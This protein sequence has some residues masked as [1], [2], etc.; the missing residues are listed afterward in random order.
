MIV[1]IKFKKNHKVS[2]VTVC[3]TIWLVSSGTE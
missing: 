2:T 1:S 3:F